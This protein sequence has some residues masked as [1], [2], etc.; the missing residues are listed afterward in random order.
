MENFTDLYL[1]GFSSRNSVHLER[2]HSLLKE[3]DFQNSTIGLILIHDGVIG[4]IKTGNM[5]KAM[6]DVLNLPL[7]VFTM[8]PDLRARGIPL[9]FIHDKI[10][11]IGYNELVD[12]INN[13]E[14][15]ISWI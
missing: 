6:E 11:V 13:S 3:Q 7:R 15:L 14:K 9:E 1:F 8:E 5:P 10:T 2:L 4:T 12:I